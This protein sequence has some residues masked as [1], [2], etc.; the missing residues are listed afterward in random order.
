MNTY[1]IQLL[2]DDH[3]LETSTVTAHT[4]MEAHVRAVD[5]RRAQAIR[6]HRPDLKIELAGITLTRRAA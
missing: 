2:V 3:L 5:L 6:A 1:T 4:A